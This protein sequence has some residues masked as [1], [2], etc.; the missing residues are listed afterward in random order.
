MAGV[1]LGGDL[2][3]YTLR[4]GL[5]L[6]ENEEMN[7]DWMQP[8]LN[9]KLLCVLRMILVTYAAFVCWSLCWG[10]LFYTCKYQYLDPGQAPCFLPSSGFTCARFLE[11]VS[12]TSIN[13]SAS[14]VEATKIRQLQ[15]NILR[16]NPPLFTCSLSPAEVSSLLSCFFSGAPLAY[17]PFRTYLTQ[18]LCTASPTIHLRARFLLPV[19][20]Q[21]QRSARSGS[22]QGGLSARGS[23][24][25]VK[26]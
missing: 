6:S 25:A 17:C 9:K 15:S 19:A 16:A 4:R 3:S 20:S 8:F 23:P 1:P 24:V 26:F 14:A 22:T 12:D 7:E 2:C 13:S 21:A 10:S 5:F 11:N 18:R